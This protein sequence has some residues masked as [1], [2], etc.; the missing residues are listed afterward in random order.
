M[1]I[2]PRSYGDDDS[3]YCLNMDLPSEQDV[4]NISLGDQVD[5][6]IT[7]VVKG[8]DAEC[9]EPD[10]SYE[11]KA[12]QKRRTKTRPARIEVEL[13]SDPAFKGI[14]ELNLNMRDGDD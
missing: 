2:E 12:G 3:P 5:I 13:T 9:E 1:Y 14:E 10:Y 6:R 4:K 11:P 7:G 8:L